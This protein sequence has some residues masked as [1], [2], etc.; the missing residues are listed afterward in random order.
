MNGP[1]QCFFNDLSVRQKLLTGFG[2][3]LAITLLV[4]WTSWRALEGALHR[5]DILLRVSEIDTKLYQVRQHEKDFII[6]SDEQSI[7]SALQIIGEIQGIAD[8]ALKVMTIPRTI[9]LMKQIQTD[10]GQYQLKLAALV[11][12]EHGKRDTQASMEEAAREALK[13][14]D[15]LEQH[16]TQEALQQ[17]RQSGDENGIRALESANHASGMAKDMLAARRHEKN[18]IMRGDNQDADKLNAL[19]DSLDDRADELAARIGDPSAQEDLV[20]A[21]K[22]IERYRSEF[23][24]L[25]QSVQSHDK[26]ESELATR[27]SG[28]SD[29]STDALNM[30][31]Q[32]LEADAR[33]AKTILASSAAI[34]FV[35]GLLAALLIAQLIVTPLRQAV[36]QARKVAAGDLTSDIHSDRKDELGQLMQA[37]QDMT[38]SLRGLLT[39]LSNGIEQLATAAEEM[40][41][42]TEQTSA[43]VTQQK[44]ETEQVATAMHQM[45]TTVQDVARNAESAADS[46]GHADRQA[47]HGTAVVQ[48]AIQ[49]IESLARAIEQSAG[50]IERLKHD[51]TN[52]GAVLDVIKS[53]AEQTNLL[54]LNAAIEA[55]RAGEA[56]RG[57][58]VVADE[59]RALARRTQESTTQIEQLVS[60]LQDGAQ[61]AVDMMGRSR[62]QA[63]DT[64]DAA[65]QAGD[66]LEA[67]NSSVSNIQQLNQQ[68][69]TAAE[70]QSAVAEEINR[71]V[72][73]IRDVAEQSAAATEETSAA[74]ID[75]AR[76]GSELQTEVNRFRLA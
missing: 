32:L 65:K 8:N 14:F 38:E 44:M 34:G 37:M 26:S 60:T 50:A 48:Q 67:I 73:N 35:V 43:G 31:L 24:N 75:L 57:F 72:T 51:S 71:S 61:S 42:V 40:S 11:E 52:I 25:Q 16:L 64:V 3:V 68:I 66:A 62:T 17:I 59:V 21:R 22:Q 23:A 27:A 56:G 29:S 63:G 10:L 12:A 13:Q 1:I 28:I 76:L 58:A 20:S 2:L 4:A 18:F 55:A 9:D 41:A 5:F 45:V 30:Q 46:A 15:E 6:R 70:Q 53:I 69:A 49:R 19:F 74:S 33:Q 47:Q 39:R 36:H 54:A 7:R